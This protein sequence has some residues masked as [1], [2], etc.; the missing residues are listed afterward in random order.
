MILEKNDGLTSSERQEEESNKPKVCHRPAGTSSSCPHASW[1]S[2]LFYKDHLVITMQYSSR[3]Q[4]QSFHLNQHLHWS[5]SPAVIGAGLVSVSA[6]WFWSAR[7]C[8]AV[9]H[10]EINVVEELRFVWDLCLLDH[11]WYHL[12]H[13]DEEEPRNSRSC[14]GPENK[15]QCT[16][17]HRRSLPAAAL[18]VQCTY[19]HA[20]RKKK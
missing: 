18:V 19:V 8:G 13:E 5:K 15:Y 2:S 10:L 3:W 9:R 20:L 16:G 6:A 14:P 12:D 7:L 4:T 1:G 17:S 11:S